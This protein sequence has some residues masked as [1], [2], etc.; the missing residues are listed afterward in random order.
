[1]FLYEIKYNNIFDDK[2]FSL[3]RKIQDDRVP[4]YQHKDKKIFILNGCNDIN[5]WG[6]GFVLAVS[7]FCLKNHDGYVK[8]NVAKKQ[9][10]QWYAGN[11]TS[12]FNEQ[13]FELGNILPVKVNNTYTIINMITQK[14]LFNNINNRIPTVDVNGNYY[15][16]K[17]LYNVKEYF[18]KNNLFEDSIIL[19]PKVGSG[20]GRGNWNAIRKLYL[21]YLIKHNINTFIIDPNVEKDGR[22]FL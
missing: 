19:S 3:R 7:D 15:I 22:Y 1:M 10:H 13:K 2:I 20:L 21:E 16:E 6:A 18:L 14:G 11:I 4:L 5:A 8:S 9:Y 12:S 17:C